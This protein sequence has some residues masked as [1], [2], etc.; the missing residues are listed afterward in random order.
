[1]TRTFPFL[2]T[3]AWMVPSLEGIAAIATAAVPTRARPQEQPPSAFS[4]PSS[5][6]PSSVLSNGPNDARRPQKACKGAKQFPS[7]RS[8]GQLSGPVLASSAT[9]E[10]TEFRILG[11]LELSRGGRPLRLGGTRQRALLSILLLHANEV[12]S[13]DRLIDELWGSEPPRTAAS[14]LRVHVA[15]LRKVFAD[16][17]PPEEL[18]VTHPS[19]YVLRLDPEQL[20]LHRFER[21][22]ERGSRALDAGRWSEASYALHEALALWR[23]PPFAD[24]AYETFASDAVLRLEE[25][26]LTATE[27]RIE[28]D[29]ELGRH[30]DLIGELQLLVAAHSL[31]E[32]LHGQLMLA[33]YRS[34]R[35][36][37]ALEAYRTARRRLV[38]ELGIDPSPA[39]QHLERDILR[40]DP[41]LDLAS[42]GS[43][44]VDLGEAEASRP[45][46]VLV[47]DLSPRRSTD[48][49]AEEE[50][51]PDD[52]LEVVVDAVFG[53][54]GRIDSFARSGVVALFGT[55][56]ASEEDP[57]QAVLAALAIVA[58]ARDLGRDVRI[59]VGTGVARPSV[60]D[61]AERL[62]KHAQPGQIL[63]SAG[64]H[65]L[66]RLSFD[67]EPVKL[68][69]DGRP[70]TQI[71]AYQVRRRLAKPQKARGIEGLR[72]DMRGRDSELAELRAA[73]GAVL[74][75]RGQMVVV[76]GEAG[77]G[78][79]RLVAELR[80]ETLPGDGRSAPRWLEGR[81]RASGSATSY[82]PYVELL[83][84]YFGWVPEDDDREREKAIVSAALQLVRS[85]H[86]PEEQVRDMVPL[87]ANLLSVR[88]ATGASDAF[89][90]VA[91]EQLRNRTFAAVRDFV[92]ALASERPLVLV[93]EDF[94]WADALSFDL[95]THLMEVLPSTR[96]MLVCV[97]RPDPL[98]RWRRLTTLAAQKCG[99]SH[100]ELELQELS[101]VE[102]L[103][104]LRALLP[105]EDL[106]PRIQALILATSQ[107]NPFFLEEILQSLI[108]SG[109][110]YQQEGSWHALEEIE[111]LTIPETIESVIV[112]RADRLEPD[113]RQVLQTASVIGR[114]FRRSVLA[115]LVGE[116]D[117]FERALWE[118][119]NRALLYEDRV[120]PEEE[121]SFKHV[122]TQEA[123]YRSIPANHRTALHESTADAIEALYAD[124]LQE[125]YEQLAYHYERGA[126]ATKAVDYLMKAGEKSRRLYLNADAIDYFERALAWLEET[127]TPASPRRKS[128][129]E[130]SI[131]ESLGDVLKLTGKHDD[132]IDSYE[133]ALALAAQRDPLGSARLQRKLASVYHLQRRIE[134]AQAALDRARTVL[135]DHPSDHSTAWWEE[136]VEIELKLLWL[137]YFFGAA[138]VLLDAIERIRPVIEEYGTASQRGRTFNLLA[139]A[140]IRRDRAFANDE[141]LS[142]ARAALEAGEESGD[143]AELAQG[144]QVLGFC[145]LWAW[146]L[147]EAEDELRQALAVAE[148][149]GDLTLQLRCLPYL[150]LVC[151]RRGAVEEVRALAARTLEVA[152]RGQMVE[153]VAQAKAN[154]AWVAWRLGDIPGAERASKLAWDLW[155]Q[156]PGPMYRVLDWIVVWPLLGAA[157]ARDRLPEAFEHVRDLV[158]PTKQ[159]MPDDLQV[160]L[161]SA[162]MAW[163][164]GH[165]D[166]ARQSLET[167]ARAAANYGYL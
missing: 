145:L 13:S 143:L 35:Q 165:V 105:I 131:H 25:L 139:A 28:A 167:A 89:E 148:R 66:T 33:L 11:P 40:Q 80:A 127:A 76:G 48:V 107:G 84:E 49:D 68:D 20:D 103:E 106:S 27:K 8:S 67:F 19:G 91:P 112:S 57:E 155:K 17:Q 88:L 69:V 73:L 45:L 118:L 47:A 46:A 132:A 163:G 70:L 44:V 100:R 133:R 64:T 110:V 125:H 135:G 162:L 5:F 53:H 152:E 86:L 99:G 39:L 154:Q 24:V 126:N 65:R 121:F 38:D 138:D 52:V 26:R 43:L 136:R 6:P 90:N 116:G 77:V 97:S 164:R 93:L 21:L 36:A 59:G 157:L 115:H 146:R 50:E 144:H 83:S 7:R 142:Y 137:H 98:H 158:D 75:G 54:G 111:S 63:V 3:H 151:R 32:R 79:S 9:S 120:V 62:R 10:I 96:L 149:A 55:P 130:A 16:G 153:Y 129:L 37:E 140:G 122:L 166:A 159:P 94:H 60:V 51:L 78:K 101:E 117:D 29:L 119:E 58:G 104:L 114:S 150:T 15:E 34:G 1:M 41:S 102:M 30:A 87:L 108:D 18:L 74:E 61:L 23:G 92:V 81:C 4:R 72:A 124:S 156:I 113:L 141:T 82:L 56:N 161:D 42:S 123:I 160:A 12:V 71:A 147:E 14:A 95:T 85:R 109:A 22:V 134:D 31:R 128:A 2:S